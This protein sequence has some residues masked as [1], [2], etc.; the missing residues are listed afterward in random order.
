MPTTGARTRPS[1]G[2]AAL[3]AMLSSTSTSALRVARASSQAGPAAVAQGSGRSGIETNRS[4][5]PLSGA[6]S[7]MRRWNK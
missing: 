2:A 7:A 3:A 6:R 4:S 1:Q 5:A